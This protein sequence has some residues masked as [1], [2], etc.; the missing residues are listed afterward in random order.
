ML[1]KDE[2]DETV[3]PAATEE[4]QSAQV[5]PTHAAKEEEEE[6]IQYASPKPAERTPKAT[7]DLLEPE[8]TAT[9]KRRSRKGPISLII[10]LVLLALVGGGFYYW[11]NYSDLF[12]IP[13]GASD[14]WLAIKD[15]EGQEIVTREGTVFLVS[16]KVFNGSTKARRF[17]ILRAKLFDKDGKVLAEKD[18]VSGLSLS[19]D[20]VGSMQKL[21]IEKKVN[22]FKLSGE[23]NFQLRSK[24]EVPFSVIFFD[25]SIE[26][27]KEF[28]VEIVESPLL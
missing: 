25:S 14:K 22:D 27:A 2:S 16:G 24:K 17:L 26:K 28:T 5:T 10:V 6:E 21:D 15:L 11:M 19:K 8:A 7:L 13:M 23:E 12:G 4:T 9:H 20:K 18:V 1:T 3:K